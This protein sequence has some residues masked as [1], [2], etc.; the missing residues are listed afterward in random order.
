MPNVFNNAFPLECYPASGADN[1]F[2]IIKNMRKQ[3]A[4]WFSKS[5]VDAY[6][7]AQYSAA[8]L[9]ECRWD[10]SQERITTDGGRVIDQKATVYVDRTVKVGDVLM[11]ADEDC[12]DCDAPDIDTDYRIKRYRVYPNIRNTAKLK[13]ATL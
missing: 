12:P 2:G 6:G 4:W 10:D 3:K 8:V 1:D 11:L 13:A 7:H 5:G 9:I